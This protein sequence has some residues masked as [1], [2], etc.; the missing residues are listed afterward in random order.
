MT[1][2]IAERKITLTLGSKDFRHERHGKRIA[3]IACSIELAYIIAEV[4]YDTREI[5]REAIETWRRWE[6]NE[7]Y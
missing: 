7:G 6:K 5:M 1:T 2:I 3:D 4:K